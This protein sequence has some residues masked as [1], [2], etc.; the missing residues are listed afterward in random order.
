MKFLLCPFFRPFGFLLGFLVIALSFGCQKNILD[1][2]PAL[3][4]EAT[5]STLKSV[6]ITNYMVISKSETLPAGFEAQLSAFGKIVKSIPEIGVVVVEPRTSKFESKVAALSEVQ[7]VVP[8]LVARWIEPV[9]YINDANPPS[10]GSNEPY[11]GYLWGMDAID[12]P[13]A[14]NAGYKGKNA[15]VFIL[16]SGIDAEHPDLAP[17][18]DT[19]LSTSFVPGEDYNYT[20]GDPFNHG[21]HVA[22]I[23]AAADNSRGIIGVAPEAEIVAVKVLSEYNGSGAFSWINAGIVYAADNGADVIN[24]SLGATFYRNG[25]YIDDDNVLQK[26]PAVVFQQLIIAQQRAVDYAYKKGAVIITSAGNDGISLDGAGSLFK[27]PADLNNVIA[28]SATAPDYWYNSRLNGIPDPDLD[29]PA[30]YTNY[31]KSLVALAAPGGDFDF[32]EQTNWYWDMVLS[33][34]PGGYSWAAG[35]SMSTPH[36][37]GVAALIAGKSEGNITPQELTKQLLN[38]ADKLDG[39]GISEYY[40]NGRVNAFRAVTE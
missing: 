33:T 39:N 36:V 40:G 4:S 25:F 5:A 11:F 17:N 15:K 24:M 7:A 14:W 2:D 16:D 10:I 35:T 38:T 18:L 21:T 20:D 26:A 8:D 27:L 37:S 30:S 1:T 3:G 19:T 32:A 34:I 23:I 13:E 6:K 29:I 9:K 12:A 28:V 22:G 31:G